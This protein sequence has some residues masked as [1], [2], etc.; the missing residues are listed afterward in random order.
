MPQENNTLHRGD[1]EKSPPPLIFV[2]EVKNMTIRQA[3]TQVEQ[4][5][6]NA[7]PDEVLVQWL[8][9]VDQTIFKEL[10]KTHEYG[11]ELVFG[12][13]DRTDESGADSVVLLA[14]EPYSQ[15]YVYY[16][17]AQIDM[18]NQEFDL[19]RNN[20]AL[21]NKAYSDYASYYNRKIMPASEAKFNA[22]GVR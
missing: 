22:W 11:T 8:N 6:P 12:G 16:L 5:K 17:C 18:Q 2:E 21:Y 15:L 7:V 9:E 20:A 1:G 14:P 10:V 19:Y 4:V 13:Y 3:L